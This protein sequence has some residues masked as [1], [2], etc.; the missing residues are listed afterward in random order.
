MGHSWGTPLHCPWDPA[1][2][3][4]EVEDKVGELSGGTADCWF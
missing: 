1:H 2:G 4:G 3:G